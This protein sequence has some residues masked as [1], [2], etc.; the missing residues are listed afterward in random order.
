MS[1]FSTL[2]K[3]KHDETVDGL[4]KVDAKSVGRPQAVANVSSKAIRTKLQSKDESEASESES[5][6]ESESGSESESSDADEK[7]DKRIGK[8]DDDLESRY[9]QKLLQEEKPDQRETNGDED[10]EEDDDK[11]DSDSD[12]DDSD[13]DDESMEVDKP[14]T[15]KVVNMKENE[16][17]KAEKTVFVG[18]VPRTVVT[19]KSMYKRFKAY[20]SQAGKVQSIRF[21]SISFGEPLPRKIEFAQKK[22]HD[23]RETMN[24]YVVFDTK[25]ISLK[26]TKLFNGKLFENLHLRVDHIAHPAPK[27]NKRTIFVGNLDFEEAEE[28]LWRYFNSKT[29]NDVESVRIVRDPKTNMGKGFALVQFKDSLSVNKCLLLNE[30]PI[31]QESKRKLRITRAKANAKPSLLS[32]NHVEN[33]RLK[34]GN[35]QKK[36]TL[37]DKQ[38]TNLGRVKMLG[39]ADKASLKTSPLIIEGE[40][41]R[42]TTNSRKKPRH[43]KVRKPR[44][45]ERSAKFKSKLKENK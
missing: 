15:A 16:L 35:K 17:A 40:R 25:D 37:N 29:D 33:L 4:F 45:T 20:F 9:Y 7:N 10:G 6:S 1:V 43:D 38:K 42:K 18:N 41:A 23:S 30:K 28:T 22:F 27:D 12:E 32:P 11:D 2:F 31:S 5:E 39:K 13:K 3:G 19:S 36:L 21:R 8:D 34:K 14:Q 44:I 24:A 26:A